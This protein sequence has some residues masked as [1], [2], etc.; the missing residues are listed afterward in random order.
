MKV[1]GLS[2]G[3]CSGQFV[4]VVGGVGRVA[5]PISNNHQNGGEESDQKKFNRV[6]DGS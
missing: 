3:S 6:T 2:R 5:T 1:G 4:D